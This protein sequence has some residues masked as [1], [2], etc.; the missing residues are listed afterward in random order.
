MKD[1][2]GRADK[3]LGPDGIAEM[4]RLTALTLQSCCVRSH[5]FYP[6]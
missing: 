6:V 2:G 4:Q 3:K 1:G 5:N